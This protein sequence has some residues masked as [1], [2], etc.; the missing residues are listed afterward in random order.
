MPLRERH[1]IVKLF[2]KYH[3]SQVWPAHHFTFII[4]DAA[5]ICAFQ[6]HILCTSLCF[7]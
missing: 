7:Q 1:L 5:T 2:P 4:C 6:L 3:I